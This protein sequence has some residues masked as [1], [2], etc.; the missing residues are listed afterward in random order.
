M[1]PIDM[2]RTCIIFS[3]PPM[4]LHRLNHIINSTITHENKLQVVLTSLHLVM[5][6]CGLH[7]L[8]LLLLVHQAIWSLCHSFPK[9]HQEQHLDPEKIISRFKYIFL[10]LSKKKLVTFNC[11]VTN[12]ILRF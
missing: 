8:P 3:P 9:L 6:V 12:L 1:V 4:R 7:R 11:T 10:F 5:T 2:F